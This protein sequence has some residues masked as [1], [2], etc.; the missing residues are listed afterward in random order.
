MPMISMMVLVNHTF[1]NSFMSTFHHIYYNDKKYHD[2]LY[3]QVFL[4]S[5]HLRCDR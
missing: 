3:R 1:E 2:K 4:F 5:S